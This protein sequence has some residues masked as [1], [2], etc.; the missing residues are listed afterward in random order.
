M[1]ENTGD[2]VTRRVDLDGNVCYGGVYL[3][4]NDLRERGWVDEKYSP[5]VD[6]DTRFHIERSDSDNRERVVWK[7]TL[8]S[9]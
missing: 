6:F 1:T 8:R 4:Y 3:L 5:V 7:A 9:A 2:T